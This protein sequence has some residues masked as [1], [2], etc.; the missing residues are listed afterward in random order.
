[1]QPSQ[2]LAAETVPYLLVTQKAFHQAVVYLQRHLRSTPN[3][4]GFMLATIS[5]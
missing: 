3:L 5:Q 4:Q 2:H 1:M